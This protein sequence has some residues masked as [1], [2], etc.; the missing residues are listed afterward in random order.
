M[1]SISTGYTEMLLLL[2]LLQKQRTSSKPV[3]GK[4]WEWS[5]SCKRIIFRDRAFFLAI[6]KVTEVL[7]NPLIYHQCFIL[8]EKYLRIYS[9]TWGGGHLAMFLL[10]S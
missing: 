4:V 7:V 9:R 6:V 2:I 8:L 10:A 1:L 3:T 5:E